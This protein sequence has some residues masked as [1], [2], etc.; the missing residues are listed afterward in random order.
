MKIELIHVNSYRGF[1]R[2]IYSDNTSLIIS[3]TD[4]K[5][6]L[7]KYPRA[8]FTMQTIGGEPRVRNEP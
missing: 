1:C 6:L 2:A 4:A 3:H 7:D 5:R 8:T